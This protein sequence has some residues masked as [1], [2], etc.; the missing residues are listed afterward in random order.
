MAHTLLSGYSKGRL[1]YII[2]YRSQ[3]SI[4][5]VILLLT[6]FIVLLWVLNDT[7]K[8]SQWKTIK[9]ALP[10]IALAISIVSF[11]A[12]LVTIDSALPT[13]EKMRVSATY[14]P[15]LEVYFAS[16]PNA[17]NNK[18]DILWSNITGS[19]KNQQLYVSPENLRE[20]FVEVELD[21]YCEKGGNGSREYWDVKW[22]LKDNRKISED[23]ED[24]ALRFGY[25]YW[26]KSVQK[27]SE[28][29]LPADFI[30]P[31]S[32]RVKKL[33]SCCRGLSEGRYAVDRPKL[34]GSRLCST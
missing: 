2:G 13:L 3:Q 9:D 17:T 34:P 24:E 22:N 1:L 12:S 8:K 20:M 29:N 4:W 7:R 32:K 26:L 16:S 30:F 28:K 11:T 27:K 21:I 31:V 23:Y 10:Y 14:E 6:I 19:G 25:G 18:T 15:E 5:F 33:Y